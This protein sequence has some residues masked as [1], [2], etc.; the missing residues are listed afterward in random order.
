MAPGF[1]HCR[2]TATIEIE[3]SFDNGDDAIRTGRRE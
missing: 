2:T 1:P 3:P